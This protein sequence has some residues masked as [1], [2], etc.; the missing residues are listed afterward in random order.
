VLTRRATVFDAA[1]SHISARIDRVAT[2]ATTAASAGGDVTGVLAKLDVAR[3]AIATAKDTEAQAV[4]AFKAV[5][6]ATDRKA[7]FAAAKALAHTAKTSLDEART[8]LRS[9]IMALK[10]VVNGLAPVTP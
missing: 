7:V 10:V 4:V 6:D 3:A 9:A 8:S 5:P 1:A 2:M